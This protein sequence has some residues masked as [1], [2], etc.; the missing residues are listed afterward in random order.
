MIGLPSQGR[1]FLRQAATDL[2]KSFDGL[3]GLV[4]GEMDQDPMSGDLFVFVNRSRDLVKALYWDRDGF[5]IWAKRLECGRFSVPGGQE[6][7]MDRAGL[8]MLLEGV[9]AEIV[10]RSP[11]WKRGS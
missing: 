7:E 6:P 10:F 1:I 9:K 2:R 4:R 11:R 8:A 3:S 5:A